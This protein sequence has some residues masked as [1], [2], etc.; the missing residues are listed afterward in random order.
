MLLGPGVLNSYVCQM[1][2]T[3]MGKDSKGIVDK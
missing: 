3:G 2:A 1:K